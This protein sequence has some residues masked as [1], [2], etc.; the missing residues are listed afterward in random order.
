MEI[1]EIKALIDRGKYPQALEAIEALKGEERLEGLILKSRILQRKGELKE[2]LEVGKNILIECR[3][4]GGDLVV[5]KTLLTLGLVHFNLSNIPELT[6]SLQEA[7]HLLSRIKIEEQDIIQECKGL[8]AFLQGGFKALKGEIDQSLELLEKSLVIR[9]AL[10]Y[11][12]DIVD[13]LTTI[14]FTH[15][16]ITGKK[17]LAL[18]LFNRSLTISEKLGNQTA[19]AHS[20]NRVGCYYHHINNFDEALSYFEKS[21][22]LYQGLNNKEWIG[23]LYNNISLIYRVKENYDLTLNYLER[24][25]AISEELQDKRALIINHNNIGW[26]YAHKGKLTTAEEHFKQSIQLAKELGDKLSQAFISLFLGDIY[27]IWKGELNLGLEYY[28]HSLSIFEST[29]SE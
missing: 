17:E 11:Q 25:L 20:L 14:G 10:P 16:D 5:L 26:L 7:E 6:D 23:G 9:Q 1:S 27:S 19:I 15:L 4:S 12:H 8:L 21:L 13:T 29:R 28:Q 24:A 3:T 22:A 18:D 2:A